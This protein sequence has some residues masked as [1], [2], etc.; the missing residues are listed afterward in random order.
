MC[1]CS[2]SRAGGGDSP[3]LGGGVP[4]TTDPLSCLRRSAVP[5]GLSVRLVPYGEGS[6]LLSPVQDAE[7]EPVLAPGRAGLGFATM[8]F[9]C[10]WIVMLDY[11][12]SVPP[13]IHAPQCSEHRQH[14]LPSG[15]VFVTIVEA[16]ERSACVG[17][18]V[19]ERAICLLGPVVDESGD[20]G[21]VQQVG[22]P[23]GLDPSWVRSKR[24]WRGRKDV[25]QG[26]QE[27]W[28]QPGVTALPAKD[29]CDVNGP[30]A[31]AQ[32]IGNFSDVESGVC[33]GV[34]EAGRGQHIVGSGYKTQRGGDGILREG[35]RRVSVG[36][37]RRSVGSAG[38]SGSFEQ[39]RELFGDLAFSGRQAHECITVAAEVILERWRKVG[40]IVIGWVRRVV[41]A[42][43]Y[44]PPSSNRTNLSWTPR[45]ITPTRWPEILSSSPSCASV[46]SSR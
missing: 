17:A 46:M 28:N 3:D 39:R 23:R 5:G 26:S 29:L 35:R 13:W 2:T 27:G 14:V 9:A 4:T 40:E 7:A 36:R 1:G 25:G 42:H 16:G 22:H 12:S 8:R 37:R 43:G 34:L 10:C 6:L 15:G 45:R 41:V 32:A 33:A 30:P 19:V 24:I 11:F 44:S 38:C 21:I 31:R 18:D 20:D